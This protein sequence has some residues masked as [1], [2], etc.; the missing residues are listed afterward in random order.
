MLTTADKRAAFK[1]LHESGCFIIPNPFDVGSAKA[2]Q[3]LGFKALAS[4]SAGFAW[5][6][7]KADN[8]VTVDDVCNHLTAV[9]AAVDI[10]V[11]ADYEGGFA[12]EPDKVAVNVARGVKTGVAGLSIEDSTGDATKPLFDFE[13]AVERIKAARKAIDADNSGVLLTGRCEAFLWGQPDLKLVIERL[14]AYS[15][16]GADVLYAPGIKTKDEIAAVVKAVA[17]KP[18]NLLIGAPGLSLQEAGDLGVRRVSVGGSLARMAWA[19]VMKAAK[20]MAEK[21][22]FTEFANGYPGGELNKMFK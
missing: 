9:C 12:V 6:I 11:N 18:V 19:G 5:T 7:G 10:P 15:A 20:E 21:G 2:L 8:R 16:A 3:H 14:Q 13:L 4:T 22:T 1:K 17:P